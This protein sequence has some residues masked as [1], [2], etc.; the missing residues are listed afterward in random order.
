MIKIFL[1]QQ[2]VYGFIQNKKQL[3]L[4]LILLTIIISKAKL[5]GNTGRDGANKTLRNATIAVSL[6][7]LSN[8]WGSLKL[9]LI[10]W[11]VELKLKW[12]KY[13]VLFAAGADDVNGNDNGNIILLSETQNCILNQEDN[14]KLFKLLRKGFERSVYWNEYKTKGGNKN[15]TNEL[16]YFL[17]S[18]FIGVNRLF[19]LVYSNEDDDSKRSKTRRYYLPKGIIRNYNVI[20]NG[21]NFYDQPVDSNIKRYEE[22]RKLTTG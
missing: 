9:S 6:K 5:L 20:I 15:T 11:K 17:E 22:I 19:V 10:N 14:Q 2:E 4:M 3:I 18:N 21:K 8:F 13:C 16:R 7:Y 1:K 12:T